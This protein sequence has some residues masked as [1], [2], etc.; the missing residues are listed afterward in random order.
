[1][2]ERKSHESNS[3]CQDNLSQ[4]KYPGKDKKLDVKRFLRT[5][6]KIVV[7]F[8][9]I[10]QPTP[11]SEYAMMLTIPDVSRSSSEQ[12]DTTLSS[13]GDM[14]S[15]DSRVVGDI[16]G[17]WQSVPSVSVST[18]PLYSPSSNSSYSLWVRVLLSNYLF[19]F[20]SISYLT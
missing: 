2:I 13:T 19:R 1:M 7:C 10:L 20:F 3:S 16:R 15:W 9:I 14:V 5:C 18:R 11:F 12:G 6:C 17:D 4:A 8:Q